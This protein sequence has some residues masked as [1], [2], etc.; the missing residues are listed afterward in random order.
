MKLAGFNFTKIVGER[1]N[2]KFEELKINSTL[3]LKE[4]KEISSDLIKTKEDL[5][6]VRFF[7]SIEYS[8]KVAKIEFEGNII[9][10]LDSKQAK[11]ILKEW[12]DKKV[13]SSFKEAIFNLI[14][15]KCNIK[16]LQLEE[17]LGLPIHFK[18]PSIKIEEPKK[19]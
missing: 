8:Q 16:A 5:L 9:I 13:K 18:L 12:D 11:E 4:I 14:L 15:N 7:Y 6:G 17:E 10:S 19:D 1:S 3:D 2:I